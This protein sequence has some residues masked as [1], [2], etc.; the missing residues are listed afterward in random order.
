MNTMITDNEVKQS[1][2]DYM[3]Q[4][5]WA[6]GLK[7][8]PT[9]KGL[10]SIMNAFKTNKA[11]L[12]KMFEK[13]PHYNGKY[14]IVLKDE[15]YQRKIDTHE[16]HMLTYFL[17]SKLPKMNNFNLHDKNIFVTCS[18]L[19]TYNYTNSYSLSKVVEMDVERGTMEI[20][21][22]ISEAPIALGE[23]YEVD[24]L[25]FVTASPKEIV[26]KMKADNRVPYFFDPDIKERVGT[27]EYL[28]KLS[29]KET[30]SFEE[31]QESY[32]ND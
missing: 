10:D 11:D 30:E 31:I 32:T 13:S 18:L 29:E 9:E 28:Q 1:M 5:E 19:N 2:K 4:F 22:L 16:I 15:T 24:I 21:V 6:Y 17:Y 3:N 27:Y 8:N 12:I 14:Q 20:E 26:E 25:K 7:Y 23:V